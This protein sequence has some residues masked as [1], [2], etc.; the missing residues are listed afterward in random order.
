MSPAAATTAEEAMASSAGSGER[1][2]SPG[3][4][5]RATDIQCHTESPTGQE[6][7]PDVERWAAAVPP[8]RNEVAQKYMKLQ[9]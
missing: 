3:D 1:G 8:V 9:G 7:T 2:V 5:T 4:N 6:T